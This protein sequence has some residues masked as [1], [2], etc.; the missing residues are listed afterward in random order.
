[1][2]AYPGVLR[3]VRCCSTNTTPTPSSMPANDGLSRVNLWHS[4]P[5]LLHALNTKTDTNTYSMQMVYP[6]LCCDIVHVHVLSVSNTLNTKNYTMHMAFLLV[7]ASLPRVVL[8]HGPASWWHTPISGHIEGL[9]GRSPPVIGVHSFPG[10]V[11][12]KV[13]HQKGN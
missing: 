12:C 10:R 2:K 7:M 6:E 4:T 9:S 5:S 3:M 13:N 11:S 8:W 1:M